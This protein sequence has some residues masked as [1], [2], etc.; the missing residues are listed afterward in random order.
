MT[1]IH[2][3]LEQDH[4]SVKNDL[5]KIGLTEGEGKTERAMLF[6]RVRSALKVHMDF[7]EKTF[8]PAAREA[9][10]MVD[11]VRDGVQEHREA[12]DLL[13]EISD[14]DQASNEW[15]DKVN[16]LA[17]ALDHHIRDEEEKLFPRSREKLTADQKNAM[18]SDYQKLVDEAEAAG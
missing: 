16:D 12:K 2:D 13:A 3:L 18:G 15:R 14:L 5:S 4:R 1:D 17:A 8:Y 11:Q 10:G 9:T 7:E 6:G